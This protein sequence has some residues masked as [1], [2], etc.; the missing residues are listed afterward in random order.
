MVNQTCTNRHLSP[1]DLHLS[2][3]GHNVIAMPH[4]T[5]RM[6]S[7]LDDARRQSG[8]TLREIEDTTHI[9][10]STL[11]KIFA[12][13]S[14]PNILHIEKLATLFG[15]TITTLIGQAEQTDAAA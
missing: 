13:E 8:L 10:R 1:F 2:R 9:P 14:V 5:A 12:G 3:W 6:A 11:G 4:I 15:T 7:L